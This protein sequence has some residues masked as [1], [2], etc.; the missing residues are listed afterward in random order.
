MNLQNPTTFPVAFLVVTVLSANSLFA[1]DTAE[2]PMVKSV[3]AQP[4][5][6]SIERLIEAMDY[7]GN[8]V[9]KSVMTDLKRLS[10]AD[11]ATHVTKRVQELLD[12]LCLVGVS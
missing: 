3:E 4:L 11:N 9:P 2:L 7:V 1:A 8:P 6:A 12:P 10:A 5:L